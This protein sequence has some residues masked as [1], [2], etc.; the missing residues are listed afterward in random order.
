MRRTSTETS[1]DL[2]RRPL[3]RAVWALLPLF[4]ACGPDTTLESVASSATTL[5]QEQAAALGL[6]EAPTSSEPST[7]RVAGA[8]PGGGTTGNSGKKTSK[9]TAR[10]PM[11][12]QPVPLTGAVVRGTEPAAARSLSETLGRLRQ[13]AQVEE[14]RLLG[15]WLSDKTLS[16]LPERDQAMLPIAPRRLQQAL[17]GEVVAVR[18]EGGRALV[19]LAAPRRRRVLVFYLERNQWRWDLLA[20]VSALTSGP[21]LPGVA[22]G[23]PETLPTLREAVEGIRG[24]GPLVAAFETSLG[25]FRCELAEVQSRAS[26]ALF[27]SLARGRVK[28]LVSDGDGPRSWQAVPY[29]DGTLLQTQEGEVIAGGSRGG[30][31]ESGLR[32]DDEL[33]LDETFR[34]RGALVLDH[35]GP[36]TASGRF[37]VAIRAQPEWR[38]RYARIGTCRDLDVLTRIARA[39]TATRLV[40]VELQRGY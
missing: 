26:V 36:G 6:A 20:E 7:E 40:T 5:V 10:S 21:T 37:R 19:E 13:L 18:F 14:V 9:G 23:G 30:H 17:Q 31:G 12:W 38:D 2:R 24:V 8:A 28:S 35:D 32:I 4:A 34:D 1:R 27:A 25:T 15:G 22:Q 39:S 11:P 3:T 16:R 29:Y 33:R